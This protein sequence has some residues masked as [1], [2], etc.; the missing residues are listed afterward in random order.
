MEQQM[1]LEA[2]HP[3]ALVIR[4][5]ARTG[6]GVA[7]WLEHSLHETSRLNDVLEI[8]YGAYAEAEASLGWLNAKGTCAG[9]RRFDPT[10][11]S[12]ELLSRLGREFA[13]RSEAIAHMKL[14]VTTATAA[15]KAS[16]TEAG[17]PITWDLI[18]TEA[19]TERAEFTLNI[20][21]AASPQTLE[22]LVR[23]VVD[24]VEQLLELR[25]SFSQFECFSP[26]APVPTHR[27]I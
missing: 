19:D 25:C 11:W 10:Q 16:V 3:R 27:L 21:V 15:M 17:G 18:G 26:R 22:H 20:R 2:Q 8:D 1:E 13:A 7:A 4:L 24:Q 23:I 6:E 14:L 9:E 5:S 12:T